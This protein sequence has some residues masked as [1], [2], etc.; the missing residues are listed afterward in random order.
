M[1]LSTMTRYEIETYIETLTEKLHK[2]EMM[3]IENEYRVIERQILIA[4]CYLV[5]LSKIEK[6]KIYPLKDSPKH[7]FKVD[8]LKGIFAWGFFI[9]GEESESAIPVSLLKL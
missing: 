8:Y 1:N 9:G 3:G 7:Y 4:E 6:G 2:A 5:D